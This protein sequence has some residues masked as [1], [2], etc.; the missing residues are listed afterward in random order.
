LT[1]REINEFLMDYLDG[2]LPTAQHQTFERHVAICPDCAAYLATYRTTVA[3]E[4]QAF[5][6]DPHAATAPPEL[7]DAIL[8]AVNAQR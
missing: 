7:I 4:K 1:C 3:M 6:D 5:A 8:R 2:A